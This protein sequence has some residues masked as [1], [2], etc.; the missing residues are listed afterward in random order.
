MN[1][2]FMVMNLLVD[3]FKQA[4]KI[5][6]SKR[7]PKKSVGEVNKII[8][9]LKMVTKNLCTLELKQGNIYLDFTERARRTNERLFINYLFYYLNPIFFYLFIQIF[10]FSLIVCQISTCLRLIYFKLK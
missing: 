3:S 1:L 9:N 6:L 7:H 8:S 4:R 5:K 10:V 2:F